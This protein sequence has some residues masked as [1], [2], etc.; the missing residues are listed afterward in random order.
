[1][2]NSSHPTVEVP[3]PLR[4]SALVLN[5]EPLPKIP[6]QVIRTSLKASTIDGILSAIFTNITSGVLLINFLLYLGATSIEVGLLSSIPMLVNLLQPLG[7]YLADRTTSRRW[8]ILTMFGPA[9]LVWL[10]LVAGIGWL[11]WSGREPHSLIAWTL[12]IICLSSIFT[13][14][15]TSAWFSWMAAL[16]PPRLRG[17]YFGLRNSATSL[18]NLLSVPILG[19]IVS[20]FPGG[21]LHGYSVL[22]FVA[23]V[24][25][26]LSVACQ[27]K[28]ADVNPQMTPVPCATNQNEENAPS[29]TE[30][31]RILK[32]T[33]FLKLLVYFSIW[34]FA[35]NMSGPFF[36]LYMLKN[37]GLD[38][39]TVTVYTS[40]LFGAN[41][42]MLMVWG[43]L[44]DKVGNRPLLLLVNLVASVVPILWLGT[45]TDPVSMWI[46]LP[47]IHLMLGGSGAA[48]DLCNS[49]IQ[50]AVAPV[51]RP[52]QYFAIAA[53]T[54]GV[55]SG[56]GSAVGGFLAELDA[57]RRLHGLFTLSAVLRLVALLPLIFVQEPRSQPFTQ[58]IANII[59]PFKQWAWGM[60]HRA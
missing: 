15:G 51:Y 54:I 3:D 53:A 33:N 21:T 30:K 16:V 36:N 10:I 39:S 23:V 20:S 50:M 6:K 56:L 40:L 52:S 22:L 58:V 17:R 47:I 8:Y 27:S 7:A 38:I 31:P 32:D 14:L 26:I 11:S 12:A 37:L 5:S 49:N 19:F 59:I 2:D 34:P 18:T 43:K 9:K 45:G 46:W 57:S 42:V 28:M 25:G 4:A 55:S 48:H 29:S 60:G 24:I 13:A 41:L 1:M 44:A 35:M